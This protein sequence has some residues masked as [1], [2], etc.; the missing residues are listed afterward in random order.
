[1][2]ESRTNRAKER[3]DISAALEVRFVTHTFNKDIIFVMENRLRD[4]AKK[5]FGV[6]LDALPESVVDA[7]LERAWRRH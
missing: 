1:M 4:F 7:A 3:K 5:R 6:D 2:L